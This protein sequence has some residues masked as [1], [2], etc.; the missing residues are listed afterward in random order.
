[1]IS[2]RWRRTRIA[3]RKKTMSIFA[4]HQAVPAIVQYDLKQAMLTSTSGSVCFVA[5]IIPLALAFFL[6]LFLTIDFG[7]F[8]QTA[9]VL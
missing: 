3:K 4:D 8:R 6:F 5:S 7:Q 9:V 2:M 1:M